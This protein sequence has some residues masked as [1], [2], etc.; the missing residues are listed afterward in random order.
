[1]DDV[2]ALMKRYDSTGTGTI[3]FADFVEMM[4]H[5]SSFKRVS[6]T[7]TRVRS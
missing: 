3:N 6:A 1:M 7:T 4:T 5:A 2:E